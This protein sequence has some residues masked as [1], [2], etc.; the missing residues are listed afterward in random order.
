MLAYLLHFEQ[1]FVL[2]H[3]YIVRGKSETSCGEHTELEPSPCPGWGEMPNGDRGKMP[4]VCQLAFVSWR[5][6]EKRDG[7]EGKTQQWEKK[8]R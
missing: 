5:I 3:I 4:G 6:E 7:G 8:S 2:F 1:L